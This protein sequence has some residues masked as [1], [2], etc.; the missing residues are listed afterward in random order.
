MDPSAKTLLAICFLRSNL[1]HLSGEPSLPRKQAAALLCLT[2]NR[3]DYRLRAIGAAC[4]TS[5]ASVHVVRSANTC[6]PLRLPGGE[7]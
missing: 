6:P 2:Y 1:L 3:V 7:A 4:Q 5:G